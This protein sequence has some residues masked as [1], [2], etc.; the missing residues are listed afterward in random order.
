MKTNKL[1]LMSITF[2][3]LFSLS[4]LAADEIQASKFLKGTA[5]LY[6]GNPHVVVDF[7]HVKP[8]KGG[9]FVIRTKM[10]NM[11]SGAIYE[12]TFRSQEKF[13][14]PDLEHKQMQYLYSE[15]GEYSF[16]DQ[17]DF[18]QVSLTKAQL[19]EVLDYLKKDTEYDVLYFEGRP[20]A[21][22]LPNSMVFTVTETE[23]GVRGETQSN[24]TK[25][26]TLDTGLVVQVPLFINQGDVLR[27]DTRDG[28]YLER[29]KK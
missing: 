13:P 27:V 12:E 26:A 16:M 9:A 28:T 3:S 6:Q 7:Q 25:P 24:A 4:N 15:D 11:I 29:V 20:I 17:E 19:E 1:L 18:D 5:F 14:T 23:P 10:K 22:T 21:V 8:G 2:F